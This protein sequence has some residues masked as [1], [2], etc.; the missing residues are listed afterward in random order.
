MTRGRVRLD[1]PIAQ[2]R[3]RLRSVA[4]AGYRAT[5]DAVVQINRSGS[6]AI[7]SWIIQ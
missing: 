3:V 1:N 2:K 5:S 7:N 4:D 6:I